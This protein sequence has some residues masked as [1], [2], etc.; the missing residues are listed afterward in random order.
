MQLFVTYNSVVCNYSIKRLDSLTFYFSIADPT[1][2]KLSNS[3]TL[4]V[5]RTFIPDADKCSSDC[6]YGRERQAKGYSLI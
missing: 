6:R 3:K 5:C 1:F 2:D 4:I